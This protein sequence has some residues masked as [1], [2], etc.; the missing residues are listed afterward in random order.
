[1]GKY[2]DRFTKEQKMEYIAK[3]RDHIQAVSKLAKALVEK[4]EKDVLTKADIEAA[5]GSFHAY[6]FYNC[7]MIR[8]QCPKASLVAPLKEWPSHG[9]K[10]KKGEHGLLILYPVW[11]KAA[12]DIEESDGGRSSYFGAGNVFDISQTEPIEN[13]GESDDVQKV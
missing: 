7:A 9:R 3:K 12:A 11:S 2:A 4:A 13:K 6:S 5:V 8:V 10:V 1:M